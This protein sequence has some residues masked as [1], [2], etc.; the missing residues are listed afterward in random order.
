MKS[1]ETEKL[2]DSFLRLNGLLLRAVAVPFRACH[3]LS[4]EIV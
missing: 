4:G 1:A 2:I 3:D